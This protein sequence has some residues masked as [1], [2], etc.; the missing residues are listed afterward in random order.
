MYKI[1]FYLCVCLVLLIVINIAY[2]SYSFSRNRFGAVWPLRVLRSVVSFIV[3]VLFMPIFEVFISMVECEEEIDSTG[4]VHYVNHYAH[5]LICWYGEHYV[6][7]TFAILVIVAFV[8]ICIV[9]SIT[10]YESNTSN[11]NHSAR[12]HSRA[13]VFLLISKIISILLFGFFNKVLFINQ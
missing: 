7:A 6:H 9:V 12:I 8:I 13:H 11:H 3:T 10:Y 2:V 1:T 5:N 4:A